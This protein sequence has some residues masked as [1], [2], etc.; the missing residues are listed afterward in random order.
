MSASITPRLLYRLHFR[1]RALDHAAACDAFVAQ[2]AKGFD[3]AAACG[4]AGFGEFDI[5]GCRQAVVVE[6]F[7]ASAFLGH[8]SPKH[9]EFADVLD[10]GA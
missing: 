4:A 1:L 3:L 2:D 5:F 8:R 9:K 6:R 10:G 7:F